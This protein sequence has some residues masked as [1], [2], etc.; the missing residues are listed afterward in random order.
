MILTITKI[1]RPQHRVLVARD[2]A[3]G[4]LGFRVLGFRVKGLGFRGSGLGVWGLGFRVG[5]LD[6]S[7]CGYLGG[8]GVAYSPS[9]KPYMI[10]PEAKG[11]VL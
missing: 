10:L 3:V 5:G 9:P 2:P 4:S 1:G 7:F 8:L 11:W 6:L